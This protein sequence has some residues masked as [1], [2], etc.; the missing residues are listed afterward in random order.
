MI[1]LGDG[2][3]AALDAV[4]RS[5]TIG[6]PGVGSVRR[7]SRLLCREV[8]DLDDF[9]VNLLSPGAA[10]AQHPAMVSGIPSGSSVLALLCSRASAP[11]CAS[12]DVS[13]TVAL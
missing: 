3:G 4:G 6:S 13:A 11:A 5:R 7:A 1:A 9:P 2:G 10:L 12:A 8:L